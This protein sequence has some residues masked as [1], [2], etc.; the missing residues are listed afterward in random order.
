MFV[1]EKAACG[2][3]RRRVKDKFT[4]FYMRVY[5]ALHKKSRKARHKGDFPSPLPPC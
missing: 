5:H 2:N 1:H 3:R 4:F